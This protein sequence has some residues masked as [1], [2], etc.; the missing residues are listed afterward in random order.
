MLVV[1]GEQQEVGKEG[2]TIDDLRIIKNKSFVEFGTNEMSE[3]AQACRHYGM[4]DLFFAALKM[5]PKSN[6][7]PKKN[8]EKV[9]QKS[10]KKNLTKKHAS[11]KR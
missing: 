1:R 9:P 7:E 8:D 3:F 10:R 5:K 4:E 2:Q 11:K 6:D